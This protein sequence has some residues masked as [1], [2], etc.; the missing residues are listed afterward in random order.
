MKKRGIRI[1]ISLLLFIVGMLIKFDNILINNIIYLIAYLIVGFEILRKAV[2]NIFRGKIFDENFL[3]SLATIGAFFIGEFPEAVAVMLFYQIGELFQ[4]YA[5]GKSRKSIASLMDIRPDYANI[6]KEG[7]IEKVN[8]SNVK[9]GDIIIVKPGEKIPL[10]GKIIYGKTDLDTK[11]LTG[12]SLPKEVKVNDE[13]L[14]GCINLNGMIKVEVQ[15][16]FGESTVS[17]ILDLVQNASSK[18]SKSENFIT[19]FAKYY[20]Q[21][22][23]IIAAIIAI[24]PTVVIKDAEFIDWIYRAL[25]F[26]VVSCPCA[27][28]IS[29][30][31][32]FF[33]GIGR[34]SK[35]GILI[36]GSN[37]LEALANTEIVVF[38]KTGTLTEGVFTVQKIVPKEISKEELL[39]LT[40]YA[41]DSSNHPISMSIKREYKKEVDSS[42]IT[43]VKEIAGQGIIANVQG[44]VI[45]V[46][47]EKLMNEN[48]IEFVKAD[49]IGT[50][51]YVAVNRKYAGYI[52]ISDKIKKDA[53][54]TIEGL[55]EN[56]IKKII[57]L[58]GDRNDI[59]MQ[60][61]NKLGIDNIYA[62]ASEYGILKEKGKGEIIYLDDSIIKMLNKLN[63]IS[64]VRYEISIKEINEDQ[65]QTD[66][67]NTGEKSQDKEKDSS[68]GDSSN[69]GSEGDATNESENRAS[70]LSKTD[71]L[72]TGNYDNIAWEEIAYT[73]ETIY[74]AWPTI[75]LDMK[76][77]NVAEADI[78]SFS[79]T[80]DKTAQ[81]IKAQ[82]KNNTIVNLYNLYVL[83]PKFLSYF[84]SNETLLSTYY[85][86][87]YVLNAYVSANSEK[88]EEMS[89]NLTEAIN[90]FAI[91]MSNENAN[92]SEKSTI[93]K[94]NELLK[95][96]KTCISL[97]DKE[98]FYLKYKL[99]MESL[100][101][102]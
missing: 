35:D 33:S 13:V 99:T 84:E 23:V 28:V 66:S 96:L 38:D 52:V 37:Y 36:K 82:D 51:L 43:N 75:S 1:L 26:L 65:Q 32:G 17:K 46:G 10:D 95:E 59:S 97:E 20:T 79:A 63:N 76:T 12:E 57:M 3:M 92:D 62:D 39:E 48:K 74:V 21:I 24:I 56:N 53:K 60:V 68:S 2:R 6:E 58:T 71:S 80:L 78:G 101:I 16:E 9:V 73:L 19:K 85:T 22:V 30:P 50:I 25:S 69:K 45:L 40:A 72:L 29:I 55:K 90:S 34:A 87:A 67:G 81:T 11:A 5:V 100:E 77:L 44:K 91:V 4:S 54:N 47:N 89:D 61:G 14:S 15:K 31:L 49:D 86:K 42:K 83:L 18:K 88:W 7:K 102:L 94:A 64:Y 8:P 98:I 27:L 70:K 93:E 41:E